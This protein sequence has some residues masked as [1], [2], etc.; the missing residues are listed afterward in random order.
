MK[1]YLKHSV[2]MLLAFLM[3]FSTVV[4]DYS[5]IFT[6]KLFSVTANAKG[7]TNRDDGTWLFPL[8]WDYYNRFTDWA[9][10]P[11]L[12][13]V[14]TICGKNHG[15]NGDGWGDWYWSNGSMKSYHSNQGGH[16]GFDIGC[17]MVPVYAAANGFLYYYYE[18]GRGN[19]AIVEHPIGNG[20]SYYSYYQHL[21]NISIKNYNNQTIQ[22]YPGIEIKTGY[23]IAISGNT[24]VGSGFHFH[25]GIVIGPSGSPNLTNIWRLECKGWV[26][27]SEVGEGGRIINNPSN[28]PS[29]NESPEVLA[30]LV[31]HAGSVTYTKNRNEVHVGEQHKHTTNYACSTCGWYNPETINKTK[32]YDPHLRLQITK[33]SAAIRTGPYEKCTVAQNLPLNAIVLAKE[34]YTNNKGN[35]WYRLSD[36]NWVYSGNVKSLGPVSSL[37]GSLSN[38]PVSLKEGQTEKKS[39][40]ITSNYDITTIV[41]KAVNKATSAVKTLLSATPKKKNA[42]YTIEMSHLSAGNY[43]IEM[44][45]TDASGNRISSNRDVT[46]TQACA[47]PYEA[48]TTNIANGKNLKL[49]CS[50]SGATIYY[51]TNGANP[52][53]SSSVYSSSGINLY[54]SA[55]VKAIAVKGSY[56]SSVFS[57]YVTVDYCRQPSIGTTDVPEG[58][59]VTISSQSGAAIY[60]STGSGYK[61]YTAPFVVTSRTEI[62]AYAEQNGYKRSNTAT[63]TATVTVP[64]APTIKTPASG[65]KIAQDKS[66]SIQW[67]SI[68]NAAGYTVNV[69]LN[70]VQ[71]NVADVTGT[72]YALILSSAGT[73]SVSVTA[74][75]AIGT[76][77]ASTPIEIQSISPRKVQ[78]LDWSGNLYTE[79]MVSYGSDAAT[80]PEPSRRGYNFL[81]WDRDYTNVTEDI[82]INPVYKIITYT[83]TF[84]DQNGKRINAQRIPFGSSAVAPEDAIQYENGYAL[85]GWNVQATDADSECNYKNVDSNM[86]VQAVVGWADSELPMAL[87]ITSAQRTND[88]TNENYIVKVSINNIPSGH[89]TA[90]LRVSLKTAEDKLVQTEIRTVGIPAGTLHAEETFTLNYAGTASVAEAVVIGFDGNYKTGSAYSLLASSPITVI[91]D[92]VYGE[93]SEW[94]PVYPIDAD[95]VETK[96]EYR[97]RTKAYT[98]SS[99]SYLSGWTRRTDV[100]NPTT[101]FGDWGPV[102]YSNTPQYNSDTLY[103][104][105]SYPSAYNY[106]HYCC[107]WYD[108]SWCVDSIPYGNT[109][110]TKYHTISRSSPLPAITFGDMG[111]KQCYGG[112]GSGAPACANNFYIWF[113]DSVTYTYEF[114]TRSTWKTYYYYKWNDW[115]SW[116]DTYVSSSNDRQVETRTLYRYRNLEPVYDSV[117]GEEDTSGEIY[118]F[119]GALQ[120]DREL[121]LSGTVATV[122]A[123]KGK[124]SDPNESQIQYVGQIII[125][126]G[127][128]YHASFKT[129]EIPTAATGDYIVCLAVKGSTGLVNIGVIN[130]PKQKYTVSFYGFDGTLLEQQEVEEDE[131]AVIPTAPAIDGYQFITW[132]DSGT[133]IYDNMSISA[134][135]VPKTYAVVFVDW[136]NETAVPYALDAGTDLTVYADELTPEKEGYT[137][138]GWDTL[139]DGNTVVEDN[140]VVSAVYEANTYT[141]RFFAKENGENKL[142]DTQ[143]ISY[144]SA[145]QLPETPVLSGAQFLGWNTD[146]EWWNVTKDMDVYAITSYGISTQTPV[147]DLG[148]II[149]SME[150]EIALTSEED[151]S[152]FYTLDGTEPNA[153][154]NGILYTGPITLSETTVLRAVAVAPNKD[155]SDIAD[156]VFVAGSDGAYDS[157]EEKNEIESFNVDV[158]TDNLAINVNAL[159]AVSTDHMKFHIAYD[160]S[161]LSYTC[162]EEGNVVCASQVEG[163]VAVVE[164]SGNGVTVVWDAQEAT[165]LNGTLFTLPLVAGEDVGSGSYPVSVY[166]VDDGV[167]DLNTEL[168]CNRFSASVGNDY[169]ISYDPNGG[170][171]APDA[172]NK[173]KDI[174]ITLSEDMP[175]RDG[176]QFISWNTKN[177]GS[178]VSYLPGADFTDNASVTLFAQW[179][180]LHN[181]Y[182]TEIVKEST[183]TDRGVIRFTCTSCGTYYEESY[184][185][186]EH[187]DADNNGTCDYCGNSMTDVCVHD[188]IIQFTMPTCSENGKIE[189]SC[190][191]CGNTIEQVIDAKDHSYVSFIVAP[192]C[193]EKG[194]TRHVCVNCSNEY[195]DTETEELGHNIRVQTIQPNCTEQGCDICICERCGYN[196]EKNIVRALGHRMVVSSVVEPTCTHE[197][198]SISTC[199][200]CNEQ[201]YDI[202]SMLPH[203]DRDG[204]GFCDLCGIDYH[205]NEEEN[206]PNCICGQHHSGPLASIIIFFHKIVHFFKNLFGK[207]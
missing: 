3:V 91:S 116:Q 45:A 53:T 184:N 130:A 187:T 157:S 129:K 182:S 178:G 144:G 23:Q 85:L 194:Y 79:Q 193:T 173:I 120:L 30:P 27:N 8:P 80:P 10:C 60:Y 63:A 96:T 92:Y 131:D 149:Y 190:A 127:N 117:P 83:V 7:V 35:K 6:N 55:T 100:T 29:W 71:Q 78:F 72:S 82:T 48:G 1:K 31:A 65:L 52:T 167:N 196:Y 135:Y 147:S 132:S 159:S 18:S 176:Y 195:H 134:V 180:C 165:T 50:T 114:Q 42:T 199:S 183:C 73:Y 154:R 105:N 141:V 16:N 46:I 69:K 97:Y 153:E 66:V 64:V 41:I 150:D 163:N 110:S 33:Q 198:Y 95:D 126:E 177:D 168:V 204:D 113:L 124:N 137:F 111:G 185:A 145:A 170:V 172:Q 207:N 186:L 206:E 174:G 13:P 179:N 86:T 166:Y 98:T 25:F 11:G 28:P 43:R 93:W 175:N 21:T 22:Y 84:L 161:V 36:N 201:E 61:L 107:N 39:I 202:M 76:G 121:D 38:M 181:E 109:N 123:Y 101:H 142:I 203:L 106:Y 205:T 2:A 156:I 51:T 128:T 20:Y 99:S 140:Q 197:G 47:M 112:Y 17:Y 155:A 59:R 94:S 139:L 160:P 143:T 189:L 151:A 152:I 4:L 68:G 188:Y 24:G 169:T 70:G 9:G 12:D 44:V 148:S 54:N 200:V 102:Q 133:K 122:M 67:N 90:M 146:E 88:G 14:C 75:N 34:E 171:N 158:D 32:N 138:V 57:T 58:T 15:P 56:Q 125:G 103:V 162:D 87:N 164:Q 191:K 104:R 77:E 89:T 37:N 118:T 62:S 119:D 136:L 26:K 19:T 40:T 81:Y 115:S 74:H 108:N 192:T 5:S 49:A